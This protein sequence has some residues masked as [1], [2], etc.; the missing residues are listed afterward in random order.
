[1]AD[2]D[3]AKIGELEG[4]YKGLFLKARSALGV[5]SFGMAVIELGPNSDAHPDHDHAGAG[6][7]E[8]Y[9]VLQGTGEMEI[10]GETIALDAETM[11]R[12]GPETKRRIKPGAK[13]MRLLALGGVPGA[14]YEPPD[15]SEVGAPDPL[16]D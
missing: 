3:V 6:Q 2:Y 1:M 16:A 8:V 15:Y 4:F 9:V 7:E 12:V 5:K 14:V 13:G 10:E 11:V